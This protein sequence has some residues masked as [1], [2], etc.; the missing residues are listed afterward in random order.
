MALARDAVEKQ[1]SKKLRMNRWREGK[2]DHRYYVLTIDGKQVA[3]TKVSTA[4]NHKDLGDDLVKQMARQLY[5]STPFFREVIS[6][7]KSRDDYL[8]CLSEQG[9]VT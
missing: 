9:L 8:Q 3:L 6:C 4:T 5:V 2:T 1:L 7:T